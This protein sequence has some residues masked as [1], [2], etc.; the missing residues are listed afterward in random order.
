[1]MGDRI[2]AGVEMFICSFSSALFMSFGLLV[3]SEDVEGLCRST[4][5]G[6]CEEVEDK[7]EEEEVG[8]R[9]SGGEAGG[10]E[11]FSFSIMVLM[12]LE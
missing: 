6:D 3:G 7:G 2:A 10:A 9:R 11:C 4:D 1:M 8:R 5:T 12:S